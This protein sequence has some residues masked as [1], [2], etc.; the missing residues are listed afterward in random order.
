M[1][2]AK[3]IIDKYG[4]Y[5]FLCLLFI[6][7]SIISPA[8]LTVQN[9]KNILTPTTALGIVALGQTFVILIGRGSVDLSVASV[10]ATVGVVAAKMAEGK[11]SM[12]LPAAMTCLLIG[13]LVG[14][15]NGLLVTKRNVQPFIATLAMMIIL[16]GARF[17]YTG[18]APKGTFPPFLRFLGTGSVGPVPASVI[19]LALFVFVAHLVLS[20]TVYG[21]KI[22]STG[23]NINTAILS[24]YN[25]D[26][27]IIGVYL[28]SGFTA[29]IA[30]LYLAAW[31]GVA[32]SF[33]G[34]GYELDSI[35]AAVMGGTTFEG[36]RGGVL[37]T[38]AGVLI[39]MTLYNM[40]LLLHLPLQTQFIV[41]GAVI[42]LASSFYIFRRSH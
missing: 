39:I 14:L 21:R 17:I 35:A 25:T 37:G 40:V 38:I 26:L 27:I 7:S 15:V 4:I 31:I 19:S 30:G 6:S 18:A 23:A 13:L 10:M 42:I 28:I 5:I 22:Y 41:K 32:D 12:L 36:G 20:K 34:H 9:I 24:G 1:I 3:T 11:D 8:F 2:S 16:Q 29:A 33:V